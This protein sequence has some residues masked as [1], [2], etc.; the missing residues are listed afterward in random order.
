VATSSTG[1]YD[2]AVIIDC[3]TGSGVIPANSGSTFSSGT[4][5]VE[6]I[7]GPSYTSALNAGSGV[8]Q[9]RTFGYCRATGATSFSWGM[10]TPSVVQD[11]NNAINSTSKSGSGSSAQDSTSTHI[12]ITA[13]ITHNSGGRGYLLLQQSGD[14]FSWA[15]NCSAINSNG[16][17]LSSPTVTVRVMIP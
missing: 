17:T 6:L 14:G 5:D 1:N 13:S 8:L 4:G 15:V 16:T 11:T 12:G 3:I 10:G 9:F 2:D 7:Y